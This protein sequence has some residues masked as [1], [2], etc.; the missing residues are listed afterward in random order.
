MKKNKPKEF[1]E[2]NEGYIHLKVKITKDFYIPVDVYKKMMDDYK[3]AMRKEIEDK[4]ARNINGWQWGGSHITYQRQDDNNGKPK[5]LNWRE[6]PIT[7]GANII[8]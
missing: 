3:F 5:I 7:S 1:I 4:I 6:V 2:E 8:D